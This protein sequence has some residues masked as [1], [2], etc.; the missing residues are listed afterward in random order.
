MIDAVLT[1]L[2][3]PTSSGNLTTSTVTLL[4]HE[5]GPVLFDTAGWNQR[6]ALTTQLAARNL[7][8]EDIAFVLLTHLHWDHCMNFDLFPGA[9]LMV[10]EAEYRRIRDGE[11]DAAT[12]AYILDLLRDQAHP[13]TFGPGEILPGVTAL[14]TPGHTHGHMSFTLSASDIRVAVTGD[15][16]ATRSEAVAGLPSTVFGDRDAARDSMQ[17][18]IAGADV[19]VPGHDCPFRPTPGFPAVITP[20]SRLETS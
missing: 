7:S 9:R 20:T 8:P 16:L 3:V 11:L 4:E 1:G 17:Q 12:P 15:A 18:L 5:L 19:I 14:P 6:I 10:P 13:E 2:T